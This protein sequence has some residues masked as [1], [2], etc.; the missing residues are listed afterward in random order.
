MFFVAAPQ[1][2]HIRSLSLESTWSEH[3]DMA[4]ESVGL[5]LLGDGASLAVGYRRGSGCS[6]SC[7]VRA[8]LC[9]VY[10]NKEVFVL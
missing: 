10:I 8:A 9:N 7:I 4:L 1:A 6:S 5:Y 3:L 2:G